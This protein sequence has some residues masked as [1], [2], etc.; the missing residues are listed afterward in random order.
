M[1]L[2]RNVKTLRG[3]VRTRRPRSPVD[4][5][6]DMELYAGDFGNKDIL[7]Q[8]INGCDTVFHL[9]GSTTPATSN[10]N[11]IADIEENV[12]KTVRLLDL[13]VDEGVERIVFTS[14]GGT[15]YGVPNVIPTPESAATRP[16][17]SYGISKLAIEM[18]LE[19]F[20]YHHGLDYRVLRL[21]NPYGPYQTERN[22]QGVIPA[23]IKRAATGQ[24]VE[25][26]GDGS[27]AR[28]FIYIDD[29]VDALILASCHAGQHRIFNIG[30]GS[31]LSIS[32]LLSCIAEVI[33]REVDRH[34]LPARPVD[35]T[36]SVLD[37]ALA[38]KELNWKPSTTFEKGLH[39]TVENGGYSRSNQGM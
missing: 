28:D 8:V 15:V 37:I 7:R 32:E 36:R 21:S 2:H 14:S 30:S 19:V 3:L 35:V 6:N 5:L 26:W 34:F 9:V 13:C 18:Y 39:L 17:S 27:V 4:A 1:A 16:I 23:F 11:M 33:G 20:R 31:A 38:E 24:P 12:V 22:E 29:V 10:R 25:I